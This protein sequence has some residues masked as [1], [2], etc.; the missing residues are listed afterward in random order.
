M[1]Y[2]RIK[3]IAGIVF[4]I[5]LG[6]GIWAFWLEPASLTVREYS[7]SIPNW[8]AE[9]GSVKIAVLADLHIGSPFNDLN[10]LDEI[11]ARTNSLKP[12]LVVLPG[13]FVV[14][15][16]LGGS[17]VEPSDIAIR[18]EPLK[19]PLGIWAVLGNHDWWHNAEE[20]AR[21][22]SQHNIGM[23]E[24][25]AVTIQNEYGSFWL[26]G[27]SD[28]WEG[29]HDVKEVISQIS[30]DRPVIAIT[31]TPDIFVDLP[32]R[33]DLVIAGHTHGGQVYIPLIGRPLVPSQYGERYALGHIIEDERHMFVSSGLGTSILPVRFLT[34]PEIS[35]LLIS[36]E[37]H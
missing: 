26:A 18:L 20:I 14:Q 19:A 27:I 6:L 7:L 28:F 36:G 35:V 25:K 16:V 12:D 8:P 24:D 17:F 11:V 9:Q 5:F 37:P 31:H 30:T 21:A 29:P 4:V 10:R 32:A 2:K 15:G 3:L 13:D 1:K 23:L 34:P 33:F 22:L